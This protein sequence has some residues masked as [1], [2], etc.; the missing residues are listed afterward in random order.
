MNSRT[1]QGGT[2][3]RYKKKFKKIFPPDARLFEGND[4]VED[5]NSI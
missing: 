3:E 2:G 4:L 5:I 1:V